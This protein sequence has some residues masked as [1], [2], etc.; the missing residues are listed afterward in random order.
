M[1]LDRYFPEQRRRRSDS[2]K[3]I[4]VVVGIVVGVHLFLAAGWTAWTTIRKRSAPER[5]YVRY[6]DINSFPGV[7]TPSTK[8]ERPR[9]PEPPLPASPAAAQQR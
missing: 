1:R 2:R 4:L 3:Q 6:I 5:E 8:E 9:A 7:P